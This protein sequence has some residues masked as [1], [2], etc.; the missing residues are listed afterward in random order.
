VRGHKRLL[1]D[2]LQAMA[3]GGTPLCDGVEGRRSV[4]LVQALY[5]SSKTGQPVSLEAT[6]ASGA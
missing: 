1:E 4:A 2:F 3:T 6:K 5:E